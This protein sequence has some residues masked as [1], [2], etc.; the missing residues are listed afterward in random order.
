MS[1]PDSSLTTTDVTVPTTNPTPSISRN[2]KFLDIISKAI[3][4]SHEAISIPEIIQQCYGEDASIFETEGD[5]NDNL[6]VGLLDAALDKID[7]ELIGHVKSVIREQGAEKKLNCLD[8]A[9]SKVEEMEIKAQ[10]VE[11]YDRQSAQDAIRLSRIP[12]GISIEDVMLFQAYLIHKDAREDLKKSVA[13]YK[14][15]C[16]DLEEKINQQ[17]N[18]VNERIEALD[19][20]HS[21]MSNAADLC[22]FNGMS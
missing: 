19:E 2:A 18:L 3:R 9:I 14:E 16:D 4:K 6:L 20:R 17:R 11:E 12:E 22:S 15:E 8:E 21:K 10:E 1:D 7:Q 13:K 5:E